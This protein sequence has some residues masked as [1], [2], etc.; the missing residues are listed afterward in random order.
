MIDADRRKQ[1]WQAA[2]ASV[3]NDGASPRLA[4]EV[5]REH[6]ERVR[7]RIAAD[8]TEPG[9][10]TSDVRAARPRWLRPG[11]RGHRCTG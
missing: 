9:S 4:D 8:P 6:D 7:N 3:R 11:V 1:L 10:S 5:E 2:L